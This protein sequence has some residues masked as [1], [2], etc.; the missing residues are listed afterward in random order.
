M[1]RLIFI[2]ILS[3]SMGG[4]SG[5]LAE[6]NQIG[7]DDY[8]RSLNARIANLEMNLSKLNNLQASFVSPKQK[9]GLPKQ[10][11]D[12]ALLASTVGSAVITYSPYNFEW[13]IFSGGWYWNSTDQYSSFYSISQN[14]YV[15]LT[16]SAILSLSI[17]RTSTTA[18]DEAVTGIIVAT[19]DKATILENKTQT[20]FN[21]YPAYYN[22]FTYTTTSSWSIDEWYF[23]VSGTT[24]RYSIFT[25]VADWNANK[26]YYNLLKIGVVLPTKTLSKSNSKSQFKP[27]VSYYSAPN[28]TINFSGLPNNNS[29]LF[30]YDIAGTL[31]RNLNGNTWDGLSNDGLKVTNGFYVTNIKMPEGSVSLKILKK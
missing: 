16:Y 14:Y 27:F 1:N 9:V 11:A 25:T 2:A 10:G 21:G 23:T 19:T 18:Y 6:T 26:T 3:I 31:I 24:Y 30:I 15:S 8:Q 29:M 17:Y 7:N 13:M 28:G 5:V 20:T 4:L 12:R 22:S